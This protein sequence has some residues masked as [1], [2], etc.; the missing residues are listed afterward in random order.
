MNKNKNIIKNVRLALK[1]LGKPSL[2]SV[3]GKEIRKL[4]PTDDGY[5][6]RWILS[7]SGHFDYD[8]QLSTP[9]KYY[10]IDPNV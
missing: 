7:Q 10:W 1:T 4:D 2:S 9:K 5:R 3:I 8:R 6:F